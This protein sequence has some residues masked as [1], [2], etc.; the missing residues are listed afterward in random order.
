MVP[1]T[2]HL[3]Y[4]TKT[5][6]PEDEGQREEEEEE[7]ELEKAETVEEAMLVTHTSSQ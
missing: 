4:S 2:T 3:S 5:S 6:R 7:Q 1:L